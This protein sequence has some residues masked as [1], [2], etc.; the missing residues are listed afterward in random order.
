LTRQ[1][2][3]IMGA[4]CVKSG[5]ICLARHDDRKLDSTASR[6]PSRPVRRSRF[7]SCGRSCRLQTA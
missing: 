7:L 6:V 5:I 4:W 2:C 3:C 1:L